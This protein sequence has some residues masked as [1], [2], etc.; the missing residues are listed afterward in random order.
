MTRISKPKLQTRDSL[1]EK[2]SVNS[3]E[4]NQEV[5][6]LLPLEGLPSKVNNLSSPSFP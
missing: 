1:E 4:V 5:A 2:P 6:E 3:A